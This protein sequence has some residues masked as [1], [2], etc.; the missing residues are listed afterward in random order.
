MSCHVDMKGK[1]FASS[2]LHGVAPCRCDATVR[3]DCHSSNSTSAFCIYPKSKS[4]ILTDRQSI[5]VGCVEIKLCKVFFFKVMNKP[6]PST[7]TSTYCYYY[8]Y[9]YYR[10]STRNDEVIESVRQVYTQKTFLMNLLVEW[11]R[12]IAICRA[13]GGWM[14]EGGDG[15]WDCGDMMQW[16]K[17]SVRRGGYQESYRSNIA[18]LCILVGNRS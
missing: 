9:Y 1:R 12:G 4:K 18:S 15:R 14:E 6:P 13:R 16:G 8:Y 3:S 5:I 10:L 17:G 11:S 7:T 2:G